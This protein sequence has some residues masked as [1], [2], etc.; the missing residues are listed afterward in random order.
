MKIIIT[1]I[2]FLFSTTA[3]GEYTTSNLPKAKDHRIKITDKN[4][5]KYSKRSGFLSVKYN[6]V[7]KFLYNSCTATYISKDYLITSAHCVYNQKHGFIR[8]AKFTPES[9]GENKQNW[10]SKFI[11][12]IYVMNDYIKIEE[13]KAKKRKIKIDDNQY[14]IGP[15]YDLAILK[16]NNSAKSLSDKQTG[17]NS[18]YYLDEDPNRRIYNKNKWPVLMFSYPSDKPRESMWRQDDCF[19]DYGTEHAFFHNCYNAQGAS[20]SALLS[21]HP[22]YSPQYG[23]KRKLDESRNSTDRVFIVAVNSAIMMNGD[24]LATRLTKE[25]VKVI[26][27]ILNGNSRYSWEYM[28]TKVDLEF[29]ALYEDTIIN[30]CDNI[31]QVAVSFSNIDGK[32]ENLGFFRLK[33]EEKLRG[34]IKTPASSYLIWAS[35]LNAYGP[36]TREEGHKQKVRGVDLNMERIILREG[37]GLYENNLYCD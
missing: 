33:P 5:T 31:I 18:F 20:G 9:M 6:N 26:K 35:E 14:P 37:A 1:I 12:E 13:A 29:D 2:I 21:E 22:D 7:S 36:I 4:S 17:W 28:F 10:E 15:E 24:N 8:M 27:S 32:K 3:F 11:E 23:K 30:K 34:L 19:I 16:V 25:R